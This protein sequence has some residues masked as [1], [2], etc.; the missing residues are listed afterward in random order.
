MAG[1][2]CEGL[3]TSDHK[4][5]ISL[6]LVSFLGSIL[7]ERARFVPAPA[8]ALARGGFAQM[9]ELSDL[10]KAQVQRYISYFKA[11]RERLL[12][13]RESEKTEFISDR[14]ADDQAIFSRADVEEMLETFH[15]QTAGSVREALEA[16]V[17]VLCS[18]FTKPT[19]V[20][21][22]GFGAPALRA[23]AALTSLRMVQ[24]LPTDCS[25]VVFE[26]PLKPLTDPMQHNG[27]AIRDVCFWEILGVR[28]TWPAR[29]FVRGVDDYAQQRVAAAML[30]LSMY[31]PPDYV[32]NVGQ[33]QG[34]S[35]L[36][37]AS[38]QLLAQ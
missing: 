3:E 5:V 17:G 29:H 6:F 37:S 32:L 31:E 33:G 16:T 22:G 13:E 23:L 25:N 36:N 28:E 14:L 30:N 2:N 18:S 19:S 9:S 8:G 4:N 26:R 35:A 1:C 24:P 11:K 20:A 21:M 12:A 27:Q 10:N 15:S 38:L 34:R 7:G